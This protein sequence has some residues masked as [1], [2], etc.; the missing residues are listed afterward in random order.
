[1][2]NLM[3]IRIYTKGFNYVVS[4]VMY[5]NIYLAIGCA[6]RERA[7]RLKIKIIKNTEHRIIPIAGK[8]Y[9]SNK[10]CTL[11]WK[12]TIDQIIFIQ[13]TRNHTHPETRPQ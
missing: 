9:F 5:T 2:F 6:R 1:M 4:Y 8:I 13:I 12:L 3:H 7:V 11:K 10:L